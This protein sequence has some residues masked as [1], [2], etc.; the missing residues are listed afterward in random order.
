VVSVENQAVTLSRM[1]EIMRYLL[2]SAVAAML[3][4]TAG[5]TDTTEPLGPMEADFEVLAQS[6]EGKE[7]CWYVGSAHPDYNGHVVSWRHHF[8][9]NYGANA[10]SPLMR[11]FIEP[12]RLHEEAPD[13]FP[14]VA[15]VI[16]LYKPV[17][18]EKENQV[19]HGYV[20]S[21]V[22]QHGSSSTYDMFHQIVL[23]PWMGEEAGGDP[24][25]RDYDYNDGL[26]AVGDR[27][28]V[29]VCM[30][31]NDAGECLN[32]VYRP[33]CV[34]DFL[35]TSDIRCNNL[36]C[37]NT[38]HNAEVTFDYSSWK[39]N[40]Y[41]L[42]DGGM[43]HGRGG[44]L[45]PGE[46]EFAGH[47]LLFGWHHGNICV[48]TGGS[49]PEPT[50]P[51]APSELTAT[52]VSVSEIDLSWT[53]NSNNEDGFRIE[54][55]TGADCSDFA[56]LAAVGQNVTTYSDAGLTAETT[57]QYRVAAFNEVDQSAWSNI[58]E[59]TTLAAGTT[60]GTAPT[61]SFTV[62]CWPTA[63]CQFTDTSTGVPTSWSWVFGDGSDPSQA[64][65]PTHTY[66]SA[67]NFEVKLTAIN[68]LG[69][70]DATRTVSCTEH[71]NQGLR[72]R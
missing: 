44:E 55:C 29:P 14:L 32:L 39:A 11:R 33:A 70:S 53:D 7:I 62:S 45:R 54:R 59:A 35:G 51:A 3:V 63:T 13:T 8:E 61:A 5:C 67:G 30:E 49:A 23:W 38:L 64:Q 58:A 60:P 24:N 42:S 31:Y 10:V 71:R 56:A 1:E 68:T 43:H 15:H 26:C 22:Q 25:Y 47:A 46:G 4:V 52:A 9:T 66:G 41:T 57:Y 18:F 12:L 2:L 34:G 37:T 20:V 6:S 19:G 48:K 36:P 28:D 27:K 69:S 17:N 21:L 40:G 72:C 50:A 16:R 65:N